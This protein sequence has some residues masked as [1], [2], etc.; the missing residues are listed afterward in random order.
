[1]DLMGPSRNKS[2]EGK[3]YIMV[4][5]DDFSIFTWVILL[6]GKSKAFEQA[7]ALF[8]RIQIQKGYCI[9]RIRSDHGKEF[10]NAKFSDFCDENS[11]TQ[12]FS[13][14]IKLPNRTN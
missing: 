1:M 5:V 11:N 7:N 4:I 8:K 12:E 10:Q 9:K 3:R 13:T 2:M 6:G 14:P